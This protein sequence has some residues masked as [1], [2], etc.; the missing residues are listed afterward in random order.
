MAHKKMAK[1][2]SPGSTPL[3]GWVWMVTGLMIGLFVAFL[4]HL[5]DNYTGV[6]IE[7]TE[8]SQP[9][10]RDARAVRKLEQDTV[11][12]PERTRFD[13]YTILPEMEIA[14]PDDEIETETKPPKHPVLKQ[15]GKFILQAGSFKTVDQADR[16][17]ASLAL[18]GVEANIQSVTINNDETWHRVRLGPYEN[19]TELNRVRSRLRQ[20]NIDAILLKLKL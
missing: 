3:P 16:M 4:V 1:K 9:K 17:K 13:F 14:I 10:Q 8:Q 19:V 6:T 18:L 2:T 20:N 12:P 7:N 11:P 5:K 15:P